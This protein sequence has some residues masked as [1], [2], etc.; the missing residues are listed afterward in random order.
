MPTETTIDT[1]TDELLCMIRDRVA[2]ITLNRPE[3]RNALSDNLSPALRR[4]I[5]SCGDNPDVGAVLLTGTGTAFCA[6]GDVKG[7]GAHRDPKKLA[8]LHEEKVADLKQRQSLLTGALHGLRKPTIAALPGAA[9]GAGLAI[10]LACDIRIAAQSAF[11]ATGYVRVGLSGDYG[12]AWLL[13]QLVGTARAREL[14][15]TGEK[16]DADRCAQIGLVNRVVPDERLQ[17]EAFAF[18]K[19]LAEGPSLALQA[20]KDNLDDALTVDFDT[21]RDRE[22]ERLIPLT[23]SADHKEAVQAFIEKRK[24]VFGGG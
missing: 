18:A 12:I 6:G 1:G 7:M 24:A 8:M 2:V 21:A 19:S 4:M 23:T 22:A 11:V 20:M 15:F 14:M 13:T 10:A 3:A 17:E 9:A 5:K 16:V